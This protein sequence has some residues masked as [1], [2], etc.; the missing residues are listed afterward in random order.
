MLLNILYYDQVHEAETVAI[1]TSSL[2]VGP[3]HISR[4]QV[5]VVAFDDLP[6]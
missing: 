6:S 3:F 2:S 4:E 1:A 5:G